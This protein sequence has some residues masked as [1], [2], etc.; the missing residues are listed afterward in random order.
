M[1]IANFADYGEI[2]A[3]ETVT[4]AGIISTLAVRQS[5]KGNRFYIFRLE[6]RSGGIKVIAWGEAFQK[7]SSFL[8]DDELV[9]VEGRIE[10]GEGQDPTLIINEVRSLDESIASTATIVNI[11]IPS[12]RIDQS[13][14]EDIFVVLGDHQGRCGVQVQMAVDEVS[15]TLLAPTRVEGSRALQRKLEERGC[16]VDWGQS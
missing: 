5:K 11:M 2:S 4:M 14:I 10:A 1:Q 9:I 13:S 15:V 3:G 8:K 12:N 6:D 16:V 7:Y